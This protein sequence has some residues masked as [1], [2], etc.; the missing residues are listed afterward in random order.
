MKKIPLTQGQFAL[1]DDEDYDWLNQWK[2]YAYKSRN[3]FYVE[4]CQRGR[5]VKMH[6]MIL[7]LKYGDGK[8]IDHKD[9][10][11]LNNQRHNLRVCNYSQ[12]NFN[13]GPQKRITSSRFKGV[14]WHKRDKIWITRIQYNNKEIHI[15]QYKNEI[16]AGKAYDRK[17]KELF[18]EF[19]RPNFPEKPTL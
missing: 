4:C 8:Q 13:K 10:N 1:V 6:R 5:R 15:G 17:A 2:W 16:K 14:H 3:T 19:A 12:N 9:G 18:G 7:G 11:G